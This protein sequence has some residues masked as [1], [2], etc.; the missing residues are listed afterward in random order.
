MEEIK[1]P[2]ESMCRD[3]FQ[4]AGCEKV[5]AGADD[6][7]NNPDGSPRHRKPEKKQSEPYYARFGFLTG[8]RT[9]D[10][11]EKRDTK[12]LSLRRPSAHLHC[13]ADEFESNPG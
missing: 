7:Q 2:W 1:L 8:N 6:Q 11:A 9:T 12:K 3:I 5:N 13:L 4:S 10:S